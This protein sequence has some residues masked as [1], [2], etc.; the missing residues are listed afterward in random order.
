MA[1][2]PPSHR[3]KRDL[4]VGAQ[5]N[6]IRIIQEVYE[7]RFLV[8]YAGPT[9]SEF[10]GHRFTFLLGFPMRVCSKDRFW[11]HEFSPSVTIYK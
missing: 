3:M 4:E 9:E 8:L 2:Y 6:Y 10:R 5:T 1:N 7:L 11:N